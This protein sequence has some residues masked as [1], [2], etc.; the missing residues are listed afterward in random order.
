[1]I[2][3]IALS[4]GLVVV[5]TS[6]FPQQGQSGFQGQSTPGVRTSTTGTTFGTPGAM[7]PSAIPGGGILQGAQTQDPGMRPIGSH[8]YNNSSEDNP[9]DSPF[10]PRK[11]RR[12]F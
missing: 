11:P 2:R 10:A 1:M 12:S 6:A 3:A 9:G 7:P 8:N 4:L 5:A